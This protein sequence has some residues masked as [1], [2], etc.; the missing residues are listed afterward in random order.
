MASLTIRDLD[1]DVKRRLRILAAQKGHSMEEEARNI[2]KQ[3]VG[4]KSAAEFI[5]VAR[6]LFAGE[7]GIEL[8]APERKNRPHIDFGAK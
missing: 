5:R 4:Q 2:L 8:Q 6:D 3:A 1:E 7:N